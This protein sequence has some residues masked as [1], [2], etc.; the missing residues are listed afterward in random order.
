MDYAR[1]QDVGTPVRFEARYRI[2]GFALVRDGTLAFPL[3]SSRH[4]VWAAALAPYLAAAGA[5]GRTQPLQVGAPRT[6]EVEETLEIPK[7]FRV[8]SLPRDRDLDFPAASLETRSET[9]DGRI[10]NSC[11]LVVKRREVPVEA[12]AGFREVVREATAASVDPVVLERGN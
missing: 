7:G 3:P 8:A 4:L 1:L 6:G 12:Y 10:R 11:R 5:D 9:R 2:P